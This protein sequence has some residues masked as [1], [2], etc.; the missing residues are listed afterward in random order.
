VR[1]P[2]L[3]AVAHGSRDHAARQTVTALARQVSQLAPDIDVQAA[4]LQHAEP[5]L[6]AALAGAG[7]EVVIVPLLLSAGYHLT[8]DIAAVARRTGARVAAPLGP[9]SMLT[10]ALGAGLAESGAPAGTPVVLAAAGSTDPRAA[11]A[12]QQQSQLLAGRLGGTVL[13]AYASAAQPTVD[14]AVATLRARSGRPVAVATYLLSPGHFHD[15][16]RQSAAAWVTAPIGGHPAVAEL[17]VARYRTACAAAQ[18]S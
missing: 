6:A 13:A 5:S 16:L 4:F 11:A 15:R 14:E 17:V 8:A 3:L 18:A 12:V 1:R 9:D 7:A 2:T 10:D